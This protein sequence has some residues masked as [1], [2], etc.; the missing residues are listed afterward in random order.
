MRAALEGAAVEND[1]SEALEAD[2]RLNLQGATS[3]V[4]QVFQPARQNCR[5]STILAHDVVGGTLVTPCV[6]LTSESHPVLPGS[7][8]ETGGPTQFLFRPAV[9]KLTV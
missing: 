1:L 9:S 8:R 5:E 7:R 6:E 2:T 3:C 4:E